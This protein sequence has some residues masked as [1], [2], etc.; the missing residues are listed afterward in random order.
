MSHYILEGHEPKSTDPITW[1]KWIASAN[2]TVAKTEVDPKIVVSTVFVGLDLGS[3]PGTPLLFETEV[4][5]ADVPSV[6]RRRV[7]YLTWAE[8]ELGHVEIV[9]D[10]RCR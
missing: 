6:D 5:E 7:R 8:A 9:R 4:M 1:Q 3:E 2:R 10:Y